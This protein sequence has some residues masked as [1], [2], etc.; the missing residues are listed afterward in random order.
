[1]VLVH[2]FDQINWL[3]GQ[4]LDVTAGALIGSGAG[5]RHV[6][7]CVHCESGSAVAE[8]ST[9]MPRFY[10]FSSLLRC[11]CERGVLTYAYTAEPSRRADD[12]QTGMDRLSA[13]GAHV[14]TVYTNDSDSSEHHDLA[15]AAFW[16][17]EL[18]H[19]L[20]CIEGHRAPEHGTAAQARAALAVALAVNRSLESGAPERI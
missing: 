19:F 1:M 10:P 8:A 18:M 5:A 11:V 12:S 2:D 7:A 9:A 6:W 14:L 16:Q 13:S 4:P 15:G 17:P 3:L 20:D